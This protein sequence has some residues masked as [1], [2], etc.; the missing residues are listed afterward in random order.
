MLKTKTYKYRLNPTKKQVQILEH[1]I[2]VCRILYNSCLADRRNH[3]IKTG[4][5]LSRIRQQEILKADKD[6]IDALHDIHSQVLQ[7]VLFRV[8]RS[9]QS[10]F[11]R[12]KERSGKVGYPRFKG[13]GC[14]DSICY[15]QE[16]GFQ[17]TPQG[18]RL[19]K[20]GT[21]RI[22]LHRDIIGQPKTCTIRRDGDKWYACFSVE[23]EPSP[24]PIPDAAIGI[25]VGIKSF[26][27]LSDGTVIDNPK[28]LRKTEKKLVRKQRQLSAKKRG[29]KNRKKARKAVAT[30]HA[31]NRNQRADFHHKLS[32]KLVNNFG[33]IAVEDLN[34]QGMVKNH[35]L[36][37]SI[38]DAGWSQ[39]L[40]FLAY[41]AENA[42]CR[43]EKVAAHY[44]S[45]NCSACGE[46]V[47]KTLADRI[48][49]CPFCGLV[50]DRDHNA[51]INILNRAGT[52]RINA[53]GE[54]ALQGPSLIQEAASVRAR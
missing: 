33:F 51:A 1:T 38:S 24:I 23:F 40:G 8:D 20:V 2:E 47:K 48:H 49:A 41:K 30:I 28:Y 18:L 9:F 44:T 3:Y 19:S 5:G 37:K 17:I 11:R 27:V 52:A 15:P 12:L 42:G 10:F 50:L 45:I 36:A 7:N 22:K 14:Y 54:A 53:C 25:D 34:I 26:V 32:R 4:K 21:V 29:S 31:K 35:H 43:V 6:R 46:R 13:E 39:F 16:P